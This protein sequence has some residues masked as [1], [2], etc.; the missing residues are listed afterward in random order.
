MRR[1]AFAK[2]I[3]ERVPTGKVLLMVKH[4]AHGGDFMDAVGKI[5]EMK[6]DDY[7]LWFHADFFSDDFSQK[8][9][10]RVAEKVVQFTS[11]GYSPV[12][13]GFIEDKASDRRLV[14]HTECKAYEVTLTAKPANEGAVITGAKTIEVEK[15]KDILDTLHSVLP[16]EGDLAP[17]MKA[18]TLDEMFGGAENA[19]TL[20]KSVEDL[21]AKLRPYVEAEVPGSQSTKPEDGSTPAKGADTANAGSAPKAQVASPEGKAEQHPPLSTRDELEKR[22]MALRRVAAKIV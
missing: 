10:D 11:I 6:E 14:E 22:R 15:V 2:S 18:K 21:L 9:R 20:S 13:Y 3:Q 7:G 1:G 12:K 4:F 8:V 5:T 16:S 17:E 19:K